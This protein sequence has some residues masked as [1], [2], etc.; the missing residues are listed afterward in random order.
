MISPIGNKLQLPALIHHVLTLHLFK[1]DDLLELGRNGR[2]LFHEV[3]V[4]L[5]PGRSRNRQTKLVE[6]A[7]VT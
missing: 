1:F 4:D 3:E 6:N 7:T 2:I 5:D